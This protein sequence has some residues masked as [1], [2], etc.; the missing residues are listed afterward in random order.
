MILIALFLAVITLP[1]CA[2]AQSRLGKLYVSVLPYDGTGEQVPSDATLM[3]RGEDKKYYIFLPGIEDLSETRVWFTG[4]D[5]IEIDGVKH[6][7]GERTEKLVPGEEAKMKAGGRTYTLHVMQGSPIPSLYIHT[8]SGN[9][10][11]IDRSKNNR[12]TG[13]LTMLLSDGALNYNG[14]LEYIK[15]RGN[16]TATFDKKGYGLKLEKG[17][18]LAHMG[19]AKRWVIT[20][21]ARDKS[22]IRNQITFAMADYVGLTYT[23]ECRQVDVYINHNYNGTYILQEKIEINDERIEIRDLKK[24]TESLNEKPLEEYPTMGAKKLKRGEFKGFDI[25]NN[26]ENITGGY[27]V[28]YENY[29]KRYGDEPSAYTTLQGKVLVVK[30]PEEASKEQ[31][32]YIS[33]FM[34]GYENA[35]F[36]EDGIDPKSGKHYSEFVDFESLVLK[37]MLEEISKNCDGNKSSQYYYKPSDNVSKVAFAG[38]A[39]DYDTTYGD[40]AR[41]GSETL[42]N[43]QSLCHNVVNATH[44]WWPQLYRKDDFFAGIQSAW[45]N[46]Y[47]PAM[48]ILIGEEEDIEGNLLSIEAYGAQVAKSA[49][50]NFTRW[51]MKQSSVNLAKTGKTFESNIEYLLEYVQDR[52]TYLNTVWMP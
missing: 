24:A 26:P 16:T 15:L 6:L 14:A 47:A 32:A 39:W 31:M 50:M 40:Y 52:H 18:D 23:P 36:A 4:V 28:E 5:Y 1:F 48:R 44:Y 29:Q 21:N 9:T 33:E 22:L 13:T 42:I 25:P 46:K 10:D 38:P 51:P 3:F 17:T 20:S 34:Q 43:P 8:Q 30:E 12:E 2:L 11:T 35:I 19:K 7:S 49:E 27:L 37:Y 41:E 45:A